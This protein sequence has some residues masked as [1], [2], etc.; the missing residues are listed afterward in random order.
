MGEAEF[1]SYLRA[2]RTRRGLTVRQLSI[3]SRVSST[4][5]S[6]LE[7]GRKRRPSPAVLRKMASGLRVPY[8]EILAAAGYLTEEK[9]SPAQLAAREIAD[10]LYALMEKLSPADR[11]SVREHILGY[12][13]VRFGASAGGVGGTTGAGQPGDRPNPGPPKK[14]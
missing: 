13:E 11:L 5:I 8:E 2:A 3:Y 14:S 12:L 10:T 1:G 7:R 4:Y 9:E 6:Q